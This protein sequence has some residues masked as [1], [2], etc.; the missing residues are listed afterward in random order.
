MHFFRAFLL[1]TGL[2]LAVAAWA[3]SA[4]APVITKQPTLH[5]VPYAQLDTQ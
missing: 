1:M 2:G 4:D 5:V 3:Q